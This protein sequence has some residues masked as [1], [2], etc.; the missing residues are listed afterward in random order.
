MQAASTP[1]D[2]SS[3]MATHLYRFQL[4]RDDWAAY[5]RMPREWRGWRRAI[6]FVIPIAMGGAMGLTFDYFDVDVTSAGDQLLAMGPFA[7]IAFLLI[8]A[9]YFVDRRHRIARRPIPAG[10]TVVAVH[11]DHLDVTEDGRSRFYAWEMLRDVA[12]GPAHV[13]LRAD[14]ADKDVVVLPLRAFDDRSDMLAFANFVEDKL[15]DPEDD[16]EDEPTANS[17]AP[18]ARGAHV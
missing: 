16:A 11:S 6:W 2:A 7:A 12:I 8:Q 9:I 3:S 18:A 15:R 13:F 1:S 10:E 4:M 17:D 5:E 14:A